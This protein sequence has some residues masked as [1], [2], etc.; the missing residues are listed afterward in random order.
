MNLAEINQRNEEAISKI[1]G[2][3]TA[4]DGEHVT[5]GGS[6][7]N[8][9]ESEVDDKRNDVNLI[10]DLACGDS[11]CIGIDMDDLDGIIAGLDNFEAMVKHFRDHIT[12]IYEGKYDEKAEAYL[13]QYIQE[14]GIPCAYDSEICKDDNIRT[15]MKLNDLINIYTALIHAAT[16]KQLVDNILTTF[17]IGAQ[18]V[19]ETETQEEK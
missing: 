11:F 3:M 1:I 2:E 5:A 9:T 17:G 6:I 4:N 19:K 10:I 12:A 8:F 13:A 7:E 16:E 18:L 15:L 14:L